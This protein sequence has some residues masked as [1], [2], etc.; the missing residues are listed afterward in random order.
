MTNEESEKIELEILKAVD[1]DDQDI[2]GVFD[3]HRDEHRKL[4]TRI[5]GIFTDLQ[6]GFI[7]QPP[8]GYYRYR[9]T[10]KG[11]KRLSNPSD[12]DKQKICIDH[13]VCPICGSGLIETDKGEE[14][15]YRYKV[16]PNDESHYKKYMGY[17]E[18]LDE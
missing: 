1:K 13:N 14:D 18:D 3:S 16:C 15:E 2:K 11:R 6:D 5:T 17:S 10:E 8:N 4:D 12:K 7:E 9:L